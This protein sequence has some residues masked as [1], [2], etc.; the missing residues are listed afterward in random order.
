MEWIS[1][2]DR[3]PE[4]PRTE[5]RFVWAFDR[6]SWAWGIGEMLGGKIR[7]AAIL[8]FDVFE[9]PIITN[10]DTDYYRPTHWKPLPAPP[11]SR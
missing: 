8:D 2:E 10:P 9:P 7:F 11:E 5:R 6:K 1:V 3:L 4:E